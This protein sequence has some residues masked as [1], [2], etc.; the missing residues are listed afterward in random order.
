MTRKLRRISNTT[1]QSSKSKYLC[2]NPAHF[3]SVVVLSKGRLTSGSSSNP[4]IKQEKMHAIDHHHI[5][6]LEYKAAARRYCSGTFL[7]GKMK[8][9]VRIV[10]T[11]KENTKN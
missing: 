3:Q 4:A 7:L 8:R 1:I 6:S 10:S 11:A 5:T 9:L 2:H